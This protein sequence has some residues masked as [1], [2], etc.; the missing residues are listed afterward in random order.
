MKVG[1]STNW[2]LQMQIYRWK[3]Q[4]R[5]LFRQFPKQI[6]ADDPYRCVFECRGEGC[7]RKDCTMQPKTVKG[8]PNELAQIP[9]SVEVRSKLCQHQW[10]WPVISLQIYF[11]MPPLPQYHVTTYIPII[12]NLRI[13]STTYSSITTKIFCR[14]FLLGIP[15]RGCKRTW[16]WL[17]HFF[18]HRFWPQITTF[19]MTTFTGNIA[20]LCTQNSLE[21]FYPNPPYELPSQLGKTRWWNNICPTRRGQKTDGSQHQ[22]LLHSGGHGI[23]CGWKK[24]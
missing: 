12:S 11:D 19:S 3:K 13:A 15:T 9:I 16:N 7:C 18:W 23:I 21:L 17:F 20:K 14:H 22:L 6:R 1:G 4:L 8:Q 10:T 5:E 24:T 2:D